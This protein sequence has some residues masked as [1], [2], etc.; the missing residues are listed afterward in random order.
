MCIRDRSS[1]DP[2]GTKDG[3]TGNGV[4]VYGFA[5][6]ALKAQGFLKLPLVKLASG[7]HTDLP[8]AGENGTLAI[9]YP[10]AIA[11]VPGTQKLLIAEDLSDSVAELDAAT[12]KV[13]RVFDVSASD[14]VPSTYPIA[15]AVTK[16][17]RRAFVALWNA[18]LLYTSRCV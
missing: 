8:K 6:G 5:N 18:C 7:R 1:S 17:G 2:T 9:P 11:I 3:D 10:A 14:A 12:G 16:D 4:V 15:I 13:E